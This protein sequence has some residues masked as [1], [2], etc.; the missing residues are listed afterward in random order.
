MLLSNKF[1]T[2]P[3]ALE[4]VASAHRA[5]GPWAA[6]AP[7]VRAEVLRRAD[8]LTVHTPLTDE[9]RSMIGEQ[10]FGQMKRGVR[11]ISVARGGI[12]DESALLD[13][14]EAGQIGGAALD[15]F[16][17]EPPGASALVRHPKVIATPHI[18]AQTAEAQLQLQGARRAGGRR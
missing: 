17:S 10:A 4:A 18:G 7:R 12:L 16:A 8:V 15:V 13:A 5:F 3:E 9:T 6:T 2:V 11:I 14:L 1:S